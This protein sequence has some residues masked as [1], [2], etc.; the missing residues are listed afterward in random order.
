M[1]DLIVGRAALL[2][3]DLQKGGYLPATAAGIGHMPGYRDRVARTVE[4]I[5]TVGA[6]GMPVVLT[7]EAHRRDLVDIGRE[8]DG[9]EGVHCL[10]GDTGT[11]LVDE[12]Q[13]LLSG[14][15]RPDGAGPVYSVVKRRYSCFFG[16][17]LEI[18]LRGLGVRTLLLAGCLTDVCVHYT[19]ADAHQHDYV[20]RVVEDCV[21]GS[22]LAAHDA[23]LAA[24]EYLQH[25]ARCQSADVV[26]AVSSPVAV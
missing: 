25:G 20:V 6:A 8:L 15:G 14:A 7:Q 23:A 1:G 3:I 11:D 5:R 12:L 24:M 10:E 26:A 19:F 9:S 18:L 22:S 17:D 2:A 16:T 13:A 21:G 4:L